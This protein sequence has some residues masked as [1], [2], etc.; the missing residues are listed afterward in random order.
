[1]QTST[2]SATKICEILNEKYGGEDIIFTRTF[3]Y[4]PRTVISDKVRV[5]VDLTKF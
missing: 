3:C 2:R 1:M 5:H 4:D